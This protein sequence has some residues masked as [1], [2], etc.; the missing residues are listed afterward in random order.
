MKNIKDRVI[1]LLIILLVVSSGKVI[2]AQE[3]EEIHTEEITVES[4]FEPSLPDIYKINLMP[5]IPV[6]E[7]DKPDFSYEVTPVKITPTVELK[8]IVPARI[9]S[10]AVDKLKRNYVKLGMGNYTTPYV[11]FFA[12]SLRS[13]NYSFGAHFKHLSSTGDIKNYAYSGYS[14][15]NVDLYGKKFTRNHTFSLNTFFD[16]KVVHYYGF[17]PA[18][19]IESVDG[20]DELKDELIQKYIS[21]GAQLK[22]YSNYLSNRK[23]N[24]AFDINYYYLYD[25]YDAEEHNILF[26]AQIDKNMEWVPSADEQILGLDAQT[27]YYFFSRTLESY[28]DGLVKVDPYYQ[29][30]FSQYTFEVGINTIVAI[31]SVTEMYFFPHL[32]AEVEIVKDHF[33]VFGGINGD[34]NKSSFK[35]LTDKNP[36]LGIHTPLEFQRD[37]ISKFAGLK[38]N[39]AE[40]FDFEFNYRN[41]DSYNVPFFRTDTVGQPYDFLNNQFTV[42]YDSVVITRISGDLGLHL[43]DKFNL[44]LHAQYN[45]FTFEVNTREAWYIPALE[46]SVAM[47]YN[48]QDKITLKGEVFGFSDMKASVPAYSLSGDGIWQLDAFETKEIK[49]AIDANLGVQYQYSKNLSA[50]LNLNNLL[51]KEY[52]LW[53]NYPVQKFNILGGIAYSF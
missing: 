45:H 18:D 46:G 21:T 14:A 24:H 42:L 28:N 37:K 5:E 36:F 17:N 41:T 13:K 26:N 8:S 48:I 40:I 50:F 9:K 30:R 2:L 32:Q 44:Q 38:G 43:K 51:S 52:Y 4:S 15:N 20:I 34:M 7:M 49:G 27:D 25:H 12:N 22:F 33:K 16:R 39:V 23:L 31:D 3:D 19:F 10:E 29:I 11:E 6:Q 1:S 53:Y 47:E 35:K